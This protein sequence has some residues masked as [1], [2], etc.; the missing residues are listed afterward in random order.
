MRSEWLVDGKESKLS[1][2]IST[3]SLPGCGW[4]HVP[5]VDLGQEKST[6]VNSLFLHS[7]CGPHSE[8]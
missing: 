2:V 6:K 1:T 3:C 8:V 7:M 5:Q 4:S